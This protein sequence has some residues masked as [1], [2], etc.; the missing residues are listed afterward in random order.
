[1]GGYCV[2]SD[3]LDHSGRLGLAAAADESRRR[4][5][6]LLGR[7][8]PDEEFPDGSQECRGIEGLREADIRIAGK[9]REG[10]VAGEEDRGE[11]LK[12]RIVDHQGAEVRAAEAG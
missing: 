6:R 4:L 1:G 11:R 10:S 9:P 12:P 2:E 3:R 7:K 5:R 8:R